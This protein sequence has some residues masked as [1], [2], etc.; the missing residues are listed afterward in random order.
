[1]RHLVEH[2]VRIGDL[3]AGQVDLARVL[4]AEAAG[5]SD[6][7]QHEVVPRVVAE[8]L[9]HAGERLR[10]QVRG[11]RRIDGL[12]VGTDLDPVR[13]ARGEPEAR[14]DD[15]AE[16]ADAL[17]F[18]RPL[19]ARCLRRRHEARAGERVARQCRGAGQLEADPIGRER[20]LRVA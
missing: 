10:G 12:G 17:H 9:L 13:L 19:G 14:V 20:V 2:H 1:V 4:H 15:E 3:V 18:A 8:R 16:V 5:R 11:A 7:G 6:L